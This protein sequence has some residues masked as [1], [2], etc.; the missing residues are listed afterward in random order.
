MIRVGLFYSWHRLPRVSRA[1]W[2]TRLVRIA[3]DLCCGS[4]EV[5]EENREVGQIGDMLEIA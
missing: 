3:Q 2:I 4:M 1:T 5:D